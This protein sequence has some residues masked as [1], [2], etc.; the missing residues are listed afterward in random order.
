MFELLKIRGERERELDGMILMVEYYTKRDVIR[1]LKSLELFR[2]RG[3][4]ELEKMRLM[5]DF[6]KRNQQK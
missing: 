6:Y 5:V 4:R 1:Y 3:V 2:E